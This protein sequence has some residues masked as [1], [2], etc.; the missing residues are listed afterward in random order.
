M[1]SPNGSFGECWSL[2]ATGNWQGFRQ[3]DDGDGNWDLIQARTANTVNEIT[4][5]SESSRSRLG[6]ARL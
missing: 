5:I 6:H 4:G 3:D 2:D 1:P